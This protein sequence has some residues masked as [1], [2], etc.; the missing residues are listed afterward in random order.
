MRVVRDGLRPSIPEGSDRGLMGLAKAC[1]A[2]DAAARPS[3]AQALEH[4][5]RS[6][7]R[8]RRMF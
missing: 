5:E 4:L 6:T 3:A 8:A 2:S 1:W 7:P